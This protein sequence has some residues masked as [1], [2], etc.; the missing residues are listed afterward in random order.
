MPSVK[1]TYDDSQLR[2]LLENMKGKKI[3]RELANDVLEDLQ[4][5]VARVTHYDHNAPDPH[6]RDSWEVQPLK[7]RDSGYSVFGDL[8]NSSTK[9]W[10]DESYASYEIARGGS[11]DAISIGLESLEGKLNSTLE[12][13]LEGLLK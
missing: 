9:S 11:H 10:Q 13:L 6:M 7:M 12:D 8:T 5:E 3:Y 4:Q 2:S 1:F